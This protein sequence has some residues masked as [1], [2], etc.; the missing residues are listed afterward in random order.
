MNPILEDYGVDFVLSGHSHNYERSFLI[1]GHYGLS[2]TFGPEHVVDGGTGDPMVDN[3]YEKTAKGLSPHTGTVYVV[4]GSASEVRPGIGNHPVMAAVLESLGSF[5]LDVDGQSAT[6]TFL[7]ETGTV[8]DTFEMNKAAACPATPVV[9]CTAAGKAKLL[10]NDKERNRDDKFLWQAKSMN[11]DPAD[12]GDPTDSANI[13]ICGYDSA[14]RL[15]AVGL[16]AGTATTA[17]K[18]SGSGFFYKDKESEVAGIKIA[19]VKTRTGGGQIFAKGKGVNL[20]V[21]GIP[22]TLPVTVQAKNDATG[23]CWESVFAPGDVVRNEPGKFLA[24]K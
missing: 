17:W 12:V 3:A 18:E 2:G 11:V 21:P 8:L 24:K 13:D 10:I 22:L 9:G 15:F 1:D 20:F 14:G 7:D 16:P 5:I 19:K 6:A 23:G 4:A